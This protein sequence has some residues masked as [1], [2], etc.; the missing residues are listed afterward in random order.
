MTW[1][2]NTHA[3]LGSL[4]EPSRGTAV[5]VPWWG[6][7][8]IGW[9]IFGLV[10]FLVL[11]LWYGEPD[12]PHVAPILIES[13]IGAVMVEGLARVI[14]VARPLPRLFG[15]ALVIA[16]LIGLSFAWTVA[17]MWVF[18]AFVGFDGIWEQ[19]GGWYFSSLL[20]FS[21]WTAMRYYARLYGIATEA[22]T[23]AQD[24]RVRRL[25]AES[26]S[27][28]T[29]LRMLRYQ[30]NPHF[31]FNVMSS[32]SALIVTR[33]LDDAQAMVERFSDFL[34]L[35]LEK[36]PPLSTPLSEELAITMRY[37]DVETLR[38]ADRLVLD[39]KVEPAARGV[40]VPSLILQ[41]LVENSIRHGL[42]RSEGPCRVTL[43][44]R[45]DLDRLKLEVADTGGKVSDGPVREG[46]GLANI[47][48]RLAAAYGEAYALHARRVEPAGF[49]TSIELPMAGPS[50]L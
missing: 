47:R 37:L 2:A 15:P 1:T 28:E 35:T 49:V 25:T 23:R 9:L 31:T 26:E 5:G 7:Q 33:R 41:P 8:A 4:R 12:W 45:C 46:V 29:L 17:R 20:V 14:T 32:I 16:C 18:A 34:R 38:F 42:E 13:L 44:A 39:M 21:L 40:M 48:S 19:F 43:S 27:R 36:D 22:R 10:S 30:I 24:E 50:L 3:L 11:T 6:V